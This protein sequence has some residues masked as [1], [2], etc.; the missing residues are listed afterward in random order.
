VELKSTTY[1][2]LNNPFC[3]LF[4]ILSAFKH[5]LNL[6]PVYKGLAV[7]TNVTWSV[8]QLLRTSS[9]TH[10]LI[11]ML[12]TTLF[13]RPSLKAVP[14][15]CHASRSSST[16]SAVLWRSSL[17]AS[18]TPMGYKQPELISA[19]ED[20]ELTIPGNLPTSQ[21]PCIHPEDVHPPLDQ[22]PLTSQE[23]RL[24]Q[25]HPIPSL[26]SRRMLMPALH[27]QAHGTRPGDCTLDPAKE[28]LGGTAVLRDSRLI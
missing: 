6:I 22:G 28:A 23:F 7:R 5:N 17:L 21:Q 11:M 3:K 26:H 25:P 15:I 12:I 10:N 18:L 8:Q 4:S 13:G 19:G 27:C 2:L 9:L 1:F 16:S 14:S 20:K 24:P